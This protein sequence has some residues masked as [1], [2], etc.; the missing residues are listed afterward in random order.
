MMDNQGL[1]NKFESLPL[2]AQ[3]Q[4]MAFIDFLQSKYESRNK[5]KPIKDYKFKDSKFIGLWQERKELEDSSKWVRKHRL[6]EW[7]ER[8]EEPSDR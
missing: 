1:Y 6:N 2:E 8:S 4:V 7:K 5:Y 3:K